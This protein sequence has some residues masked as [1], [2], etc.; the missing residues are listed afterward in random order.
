MQR[1]RKTCLSKN[2]SYYIEFLNRFWTEY[3]SYLI[4]PIKLFQ[5]SVQLFKR[6]LSGSVFAESGGSTVWFFFLFYLPPVSGL[7]WWNQTGTASRIN[8]FKRWLR[9][10]RSSSCPWKSIYSSKRSTCSCFVQVRGISF[11]CTYFKLLPPNTISP[12]STAVKYVKD[13]QK[14]SKRLGKQPSFIDE[15]LVHLDWINNGAEF[16]LVE[17]EF[18]L[19]KE[20]MHSIGDVQ[21][22][23]EQLDFWLWAAP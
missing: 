9:N 20:A 22:Y 3:Y 19:C 16:C 21:S 14:K 12:Q 7:Q 18:C 5:W 11:E 6:K 13:S 17:L 10:C 15:S 4:M 23:C 2:G 1:E 8:I